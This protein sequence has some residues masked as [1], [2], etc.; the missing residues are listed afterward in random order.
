V[1]DF[2]SENLLTYHFGIAKEIGI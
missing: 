1:Y 2:W